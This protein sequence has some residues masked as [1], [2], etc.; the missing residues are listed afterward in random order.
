MWVYKRSRTRRTISTCRARIANRKF[1]AFSGAGDEAVVAKEIGHELVAKQVIPRFE[2]HLI[3]PQA[4]AIFGIA[5]PGRK[6]VEFRGIF[7]EGR[8]KGDVE[9]NAQ[10]VQRNEAHANGS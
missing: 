8:K 1:D 2:P 9:V 5:K 10:D 6:R 4:Q 3:R 7:G